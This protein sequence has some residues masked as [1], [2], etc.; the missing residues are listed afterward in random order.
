MVDVLQERN[1]RPTNVSGRVLT[2]VRRRA[3][4]DSESGREPRATLREFQRAVEV[5]G[6]HNAEASESLIWTAVTDLNGGSRTR[7]ARTDPGRDHE[8]V[9][10]SDRQALVTPSE[11]LVAFLVMT[12]FLGERDPTTGPDVG[13]A[14]CRAD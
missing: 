6:A 12:T 9:L 2:R 1:R 5:V 8:S 13:G 14:C 7:H 10:R 4:L 3:H 11:S